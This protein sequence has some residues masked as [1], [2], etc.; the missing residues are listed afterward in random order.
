ML[1]LS[2]NEDRNSCSRKLT[3]VSKLTFLSI[4]YGYKACYFTGLLDRNTILTLVLVMFAVPGYQVSVAV[5]LLHC[6]GA[7]CNRKERIS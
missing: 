2:N 3:S 5:L 1:I 7:F 4:T 6:S